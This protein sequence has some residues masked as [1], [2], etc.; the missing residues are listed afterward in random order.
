MKT[1]K[2]LFDGVHGFKV[3][4]ISHSRYYEGLLSKDLLRFSDITKI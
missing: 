4:D 3:D 1:G 2:F